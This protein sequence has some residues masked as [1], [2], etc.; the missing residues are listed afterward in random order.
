MFRVIDFVDK[1]HFSMIVFLLLLP[2]SSA[3]SNE[4]RGECLIQGITPPSFDPDAIFQSY[5]K[6]ST[7]GSLTIPQPN[8]EDNLY[9][10]YQKPGV[11]V[12]NGNVTSYDYAV[13]PQSKI[14]V[15]CDLTGQEPQVGQNYVEAS[16]S[17]PSPS[18][19]AWSARCEYPF[20]CTDVYRVI[21]AEAIIDNN[22]VIPCKVDGLWA[23]SNVVAI[24]AAKDPQARAFFNLT[25]P[26]SNETTTTEA[27]TTTS[28]STS[29]LQSVS[30]STTFSSP[31]NNNC[32]GQD[33]Y[34]CINGCK[35][36]FEKDAIT[37]ACTALSSTQPL[38][39]S[40][41][42]C[43]GQDEYP[44]SGKCSAGLGI[45]SI[46]GA[47]TA[48]ISFNN[49]PRT[50]AC[51]KQDEYPC[52][53]LKCD[54]NLTIDF[55]TGACN[56]NSLGSS[57][58]SLPQAQDQSGFGSINTTIHAGWN[59]IAPPFFDTASWYSSCNTLDAYTLDL[60][61]RGYD[62]SSLNTPKELL[63]LGVWAY[64]KTSC[65]IIYYGNLQDS[66]TLK[67]KEGWNLLG[68]QSHS[69]EYENQTMSNCIIKSG[70]YSYENGKWESAQKLQPGKGYALE[71]EGD[72]SIATSRLAS[73]LP[74]FPSQNS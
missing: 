46:T 41:S 61:T 9:V 22:T 70:P 7:Y 8:F 42:S 33:Q 47:C 59:L 26:E 31:A 50:Y 65:S 44:C 54:G 11:V 62:Q 37:G 2:L 16:I 20:A 39:N 12:I 58:I 48:P 6:S 18:G 71:V 67:L 72:C 36:G 28:T 60:Q 32:G 49:S 64:S 21:G 25:C 10:G 13:N 63:G 1:L 29:Q 23:T 40:T 73:P 45:D 35:Q 17:V 27:S 51:G 69:F 66:Q 30:T 34:P 53:G 55:I 43:G 15:W 68:V 14:V 19:M 5:Q 38:I 52:K 57:K 24:K 56:S 74:S 3:Q 4:S